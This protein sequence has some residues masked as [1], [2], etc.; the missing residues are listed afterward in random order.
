[1]HH[2]HLSQW[3]H[4]H[5]FSQDQLRSPE[6]HTW[7]VVGIAVAMMTVEIIAGMIYDSM[8]LVADGLH[9]GSHATALSITAFAYFYARRHAQDTSFSF[10]TDK[11]NVLGGF[12]GTVLLAGFALITAGQSI[13]HFFNPV[14]IAFDSAIQVAVIGLIVNGF[15]A[16]ILGSSDHDH[17]KHGHDYAHAQ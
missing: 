16:L 5:S 12:T 1:M 4:A 6:K 11:I 9:M 7:I 15:C 14:T 10:G 13:G 8:A 3:Q 17:H 2:E